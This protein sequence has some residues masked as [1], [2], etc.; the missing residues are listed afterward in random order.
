MTHAYHETLPGYDAQQILHDG[1]EECEQRGRTVPTSIV[2]LDEDR[3]RAA[4]ERA[5][6]WNRDQE[7]GHISEAERPLLNAIWTF[8]LMFE[9]ACDLPIGKLP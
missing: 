7:V 2:M 3:F 6:A 8:Q 1:C 4:W 9:R 5:A